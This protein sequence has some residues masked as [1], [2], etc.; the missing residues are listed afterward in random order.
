MYGDFP[1]PRGRWTGNAPSAA[2]FEHFRTTGA[3]PIDGFRHQRGTSLVVSERSPVIEKWHRQQVVTEN[4][5][6]MNQRE[7]AAA[8]TGRIFGEQECGLMAEYIADDTL[9]RRPMSEGRSLCGIDEG[10]PLY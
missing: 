10:I 7:N 4:A 1:R 9:P 5:S 3:R 6:D 8:P 2:Q